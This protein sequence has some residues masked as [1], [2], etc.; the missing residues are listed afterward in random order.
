MKCKTQLTDGEKSVTLPGLPI[1]ISAAAKTEREKGSSTVRFRLDG[2]DAKGAFDILT[3]WHEE[4]TLVTLEFEDMAP[5][6]KCTLRECR[7]NLSQ[8]ELYVTVYT[9]F[10]AQEVRHWFGD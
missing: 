3:Q 8:Q 7:L 2:K 4:E 9:R 1:G 10:T 5:V 6:D